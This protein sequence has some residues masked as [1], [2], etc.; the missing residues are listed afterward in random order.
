MAP[1]IWE[2]TSCGMY[3]SLIQSVDFMPPLEFKSKEW[4][5]DI[6]FVPALRNGVTMDL[7]LQF[8]D[9]TIVSGSAGSQI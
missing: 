8:F 5:V 6:H 3:I 7:E 1:I 4:H 2:L 9:Y